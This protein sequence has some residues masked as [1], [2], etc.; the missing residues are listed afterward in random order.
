[1][2]NWFY[3]FQTSPFPVQ[4]LFGWWKD[5]YGNPGIPEWSAVPAMNPVPLADELFKKPD[6]TALEHPCSWGLPFS[7]LAVWKI[8][9]RHIRIFVARTPYTKIHIMPADMPV[10]PFDTFPKQL[11]VCGETHVAFITRASVIHTWRF[12][13]YGFRCV[14]SIS[15]RESMSSRDAISLRMVLTIL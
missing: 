10:K 9:F 12:L 1:M 13:R 15:W 14:V 5:A 4:E 2:L 8:G 3:V 11:H 6:H 7:F